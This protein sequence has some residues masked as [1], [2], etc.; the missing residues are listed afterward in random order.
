MSDLRTTDDWQTRARAMVRRQRSAWI[1]TIIVGIIGA[2]VFAEGLESGPGALRTALLLGGFLLVGA[3][4]LW[5]TIVYML[6]IDEQERDANLWGAYGGL[7]VYMS[8]FSVRYLSDAAKID[9]PLT[10]EGIFVVT[11][12]VTLAIFIW[13]RFS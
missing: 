9:V 1:G 5:G 3:S 4:L 12:L 6:V 2:I 13:K 7:T 10:H 11:M 8:L